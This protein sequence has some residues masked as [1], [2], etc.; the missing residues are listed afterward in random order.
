VKLLDFFTADGPV[1]YQRDLQGNDVRGGVL[2]LGDRA[3]PGRS[4]SDLAHE[5]GHFVEIDDTR[6]LKRG[7][8]LV[9]PQ[10]EVAGQLCDEPKTMKMTERELRVLAYQANLLEASG[11]RVDTFR[12]V[13]PMVFVPDFFFVP[14][15]DGRDA[16]LAEDVPYEKRETSRLRWLRKRVDVLRAEYTFERFRHEWNRRVLILGS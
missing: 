3:G 13:K 16:Y 11:A 10:V 2:F 15:E 6:M 14:L 12:L 8:G 5:M 9:Y 4:Q 1:R 7:W